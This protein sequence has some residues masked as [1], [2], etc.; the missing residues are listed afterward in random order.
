MA[1]LFHVGITVADLD[2][3]VSFYRDV[4][5]MDVQSLV[6]V[7]SDGFRRLTGNPRARLRTALLASGQF[8]LQLVE[9]LEGGG[10]ALKPDHHLVGASHLSFWCSD[11]AALRRQFVAQNQVPVV[12]E[13]ESV[14]PGI[15]SFYVTDPDGIPVEFIERPPTSA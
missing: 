3:S 1:E 5:G 7:D 14:V 8:Q 6:E 12:S 10:S 2:R 9:Y 13:I 4:V 11:V 15:K